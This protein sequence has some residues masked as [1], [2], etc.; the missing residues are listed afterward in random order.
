M[1][2]LGETIKINNDLNVLSSYIISF[3]SRTYPLK[4]KS[5]FVITK[6]Y[7]SKIGIFI[8]FEGVEFDNPPPTDKLLLG[9]PALIDGDPATVYLHYSG[10]VPD[11]IEVLFQGGKNLEGGWNR[12]IDRLLLQGD[13]D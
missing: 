5:C 9:A 6:I 2:S 12:R 11:Q 1:S 13:F 3:I 4:A 7:Y 10:L 8:D